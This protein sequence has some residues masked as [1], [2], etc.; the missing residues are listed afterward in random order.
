MATP[1]V[2]IPKP[3][4]DKVKAPYFFTLL[5]TAS[6]MTHIKHLQTTGESSFAQHIALD[7]LYKELP[8]LADSV[9]E[10]YQ[11]ATEKIV[12]YDSSAMSYGLTLKPLEYLKGL[13][14]MIIDSRYDII[15]KEMSNVH[16]ELD[17]VITALDGTIYKLTF[18]K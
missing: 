12:N 6:A 14:K 9:I 16:N 3:K 2:P 5:I 15:S 10:T 1:L 11:G 13:R 18:L 17:N 4:L 7:G 8:E